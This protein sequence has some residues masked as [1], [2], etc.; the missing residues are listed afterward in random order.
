MTRRIVL[1]LVCVV[2]ALAFLPPVIVRWFWV[3]NLEAAREILVQHPEFIDDVKSYGEFGSRLE[4]ASNFYGFIDPLVSAIDN[5]KQGFQG[6]VL[7][8][9]LEMAP[10]WW[11]V[12]FAA[13]DAGSHGVKWVHEESGNLAQLK[14]QAPALEQ[15]RDEPDIE[16][17]RK[18]IDEFD[19]VRPTLVMIQDRIDDTLPALQQIDLSANAFSGSL[20]AGRNDLNPVI[21]GLS[22]IVAPYAE[23]IKSNMHEVFTAA[24]FEQARIT[25][26]M[27]LI[28]TLRAA[29]WMRDVDDQIASWPLGDRLIQGYR[30][31]DST[32]SCALVFA[33]FAWIAL[34][35]FMLGVYRTEPG[36]RRP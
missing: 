27:Y 21:R 19:Q 28:E 6:E 26:Q 8:K 29:T 34:G 18:I 3:Q 20:E 13:L 24:Q 15:L 10:M 4:Q 22:S 5:A 35:I 11:R 25:R 23:P 32:L 7:S 17:I 16:T 1:V 12:S 30:T 9:S 33:G 2:V 36:Q 14:S 31:V